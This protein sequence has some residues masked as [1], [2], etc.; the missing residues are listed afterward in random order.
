MVHEAV[1]K[2]ELHCHLIGVLTPDLLRRAARRGHEVLAAPQDLR[3]VGYGEGARG[4]ADW[5]DRAGAYKSACWRTYLPILEQH[6]EDLAG[7]GVV[8]SEMMVSPMMFPRDVGAAAEAFAE[9]REQVTAMERG[10]LQVEFLFLV[11]RSLPDE[12]IAADTERCI[13][14]GGTGGISGIA[15]AGLETDQPAVR[16]QRMFDV[17]SERGLG[18]EVHAGELGGADEVAAALGLGVPIRIGHGIRA[19]DDRGV[20]QRILDTRTH[21]EFCPTSNLKMG[22]VADVAL[23]PIGHARDLG[24]S[25]S[26]NT[27]DPGAFGCTMD[28]EYELVE[29]VFSFTRADFERVLMDSLD[30]RFCPVLRGPAA[31]LARVRHQH[32]GTPA[33][34]KFK[35]SSSSTIERQPVPA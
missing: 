12:L 18:I 23:H 30:A 2:A 17:L 28:S 34:A 22:A 8:Y 3:A 35:A 26:I 13:R 32:S 33:A 4:F 25:F 27:D 5:L 7:Q 6:V 10:R 20:V 29:E 11:P 31:R 19:F 15:L 24:V 14:L 16:F 1:P 9:F 21:I